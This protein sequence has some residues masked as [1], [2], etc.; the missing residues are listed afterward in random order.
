MPMIPKLSMGCCDV[1]DVAG[2]HITAMTSPKAPGRQTSVVSIYYLGIE[3]E[4]AYTCA[5]KCF[6]FFLPTRFCSYFL[7]NAIKHR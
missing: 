4:L 5:R 6:F 1:R 7:V 2:A 3:L